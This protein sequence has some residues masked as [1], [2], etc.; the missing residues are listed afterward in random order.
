MCLVFVCSEISPSSP[1]GGGG[2][3]EL[4]RA[5]TPGLGIPMEMTPGQIME[6]SQFFLILACHGSVGFFFPR[7]RI[8]IRRCRKFIHIF[9]PKFY[10][11]IFYS[12]IVEPK[13]LSAEEK[14]V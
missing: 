8:L 3:E 2:G 11:K 5:A 6:V 13:L 9:T 12:D 14:S 1:G 7:I 4:E 10:T